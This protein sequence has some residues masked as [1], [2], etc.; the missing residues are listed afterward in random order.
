MALRKRATKGNAG[1]A[2][3]KPKTKAKPRGQTGAQAFADDSEK[4]KRPKV[5]YDRAKVDEAL[6][7]YCEGVSLE[8][9]CAEQGFSRGAFHLWV[10]DDHDGLA[11]RYR[12]AREAKAWSLIEE[13]PDIADDRSEDFKTDDRGVK[14]VDREHL[15]RS[16]LRV[17]ARQWIA[18]RV[19]RNE[20]STK[21]NLELEG[22]VDVA[23]AGAGLAEKLAK[24]RKS[25]G[26]D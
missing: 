8:V 21:S 16:A 15:Q 25:S 24:R 5:V 9:A 18:E 3:T 7:R 12:R 6:E 20:H 4:K 19:L 22:K 26:A 1:K 13:V 11:E 23:S 2:K 17:S 14:Q 10:V